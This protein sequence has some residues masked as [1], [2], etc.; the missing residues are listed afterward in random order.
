MPLGDILVIND[1]HKKAA[2]EIADLILEK[3]GN[4]KISVAIGA[5]SGAGKSEIAHVIA[6]N[7]FKSDKKLKSFIVHTDDFFLHSHQVRNELRLKTNLESIG[8][9]EI[10]IEELNYVLKSFQHGKQILLPILEFIT[11]SAYK[12]V[13]DFQDIHV[14][15]CEGLYAPILDVTYKIFVDLT[16]HDTKD[17]RAARGKEVVDEFRL[18]VLEKEHQAVSKLRE[19]VDYLITRDFSLTK[20]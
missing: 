9:S 8:P 2:R 1:N 17:F 3:D 7:L 13:V 11:S 6:Q 4:E 18:K 16:Y 12:L 5:E 10:D 15:I 20:T 14:L 19:K